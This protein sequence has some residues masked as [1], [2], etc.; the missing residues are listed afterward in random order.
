MTTEPLAVTAADVEHGLRAP[1]TENPPPVP[2]HPPKPAAAKSPPKHRKGGAPPGNRNAYRHGL[3]SPRG[4]EGSK[5][6]DRAAGTFR[7]HLEDC[8][9]AAYGE[10]SVVHAALIQTASEAARVALAE[11]KELQTAHSELDFSQRTAKR[12]AALKAMDL[13][14][15][16][17]KE[18]GIT[19]RPDA[20]AMPSDPFFEFDEE[21]RIGTL[22]ADPAPEAA[23]NPHCFSGGSKPLESSDAAGGLANASEKLTDDSKAAGTSPMAPPSV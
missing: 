5:Y 13:R 8:V 2:A 11:F 18:L 23:G 20:P 12:Q 3:Y 4:P 17:V 21:R 22:K 7:R 10:I 14:D 9:V 1:S 6:I 19:F 16:K 15:R